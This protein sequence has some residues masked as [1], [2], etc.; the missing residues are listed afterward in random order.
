[1]LF[2][3]SMNWK[4]FII[5]PLLPV[6]GLQDHIETVHDLSIAPDGHVQAGL[7]RKESERALV[8]PGRG[9]HHSNA[10]A[11]LAQMM[12]IEAGLKCNSIV[13]APADPCPF[14]CP[15]LAEDAEFICHFRCLTAEQCGTL[16]PLA[17]IADRTDMICRQCKVMGC[18]DCIPGTKDTCRTCEPGYRL[19]E[20][21]GLCYS[22]VS[23]VLLII[24]ILC[25]LFMLTIAVVFIELFTRKKTNWKGYQEAVAYRWRTRLHM[26]LGT[27]PEDG[28]DDTDNVDA[29]TQELLL[30]PLSTNLLRQPVAGAGFCLH[31]N[32]CIAMLIWS[33][34]IIYAYAF[35][36][37]MVSIDML[38]LGL[39]PAKTSQQLC[40][41]VHWGHDAQM[42]LIW[43]KTSFI[44]F[45]YLFTF[46]GSLAFGVYQLKEFVRLDDECTMGDFAAYI[47]GLPRLSGSDRA[48]DD[49]AKFIQDTTGQEVRGVSIA[50]DYIDHADQVEAAID[51]DWKK[52]SLEIRPEEPEDPENPDPKQPKLGAFR[53]LFRRWDCL[54]GF[55]MPKDPPV[56]IDVDS[57]DFDPDAQPEEPLLQGE[58]EEKPEGPTDEEITTILNE[59]ESS[60]C[61]FIVF[62]TEEVRNAAVENIA[63]KKRAGQAILYKDRKICVTKKICEPQS[64]RFRGLAH[65]HSSTFR[66]KAMAKGC[67]ITLASLAGWCILLYLPYAYYMCSFS[68]AHGEEPDAFAAMLFTGLIVGGNQGMY[69]LADVISQNA[70]FGFEDDR[71]VA[72]NY[73]Y[74]TACVLNTVLDVGV[75]LFL[76]YRQMI[77]IGAHTADDRLLSSLDSFQDIFESYPIQKIFGELLF[78]YSF[79]AC[80]M[81]PFILEGVCTIIIPF[82]VMKNVVLSHDDVRGRD[83][84]KSMEYFL[85][86]NLGRYGDIIL[87]MILC[88]LVFLCPGGFTLPMFMA[89]FF[90]HAGIYIYDHSRTLRCTP[91]FWYASTDVDYFAQMQ[92]MIPTSV[93][94][95]CVYFRLMQM[96]PRDWCT[97]YVATILG[98]LALIGHCVLHWSCVKF[99]VPRYKPPAHQPSDMTYAQ[100]ATANAHTWFSVNPV[101]CLRSKF[102]FKDDPPAIHCV[103]GKEQLQRANEKIGAYFENQK[104]GEAY[105]GNQ[106]IAAEQ[107]EAATDDQEAIKPRMDM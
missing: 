64:V 88:S 71:E 87:N 67:M 42:R 92:L 2:L 23:W 25:G 91:A 43:A 20:K 72:Y 86:M 17:K 4:L 29:H 26:P 96:Y 38:V 99:L 10:S 55:T 73:V 57:P 76:A 9:H 32:F 70:E 100:V 47:T 79:P 58:E 95:V 15:F 50:W 24:K 37:C 62:D 90:C 18:E 66:V 27:A 39:S 36:A 101:H 104:Y 68:Y 60:D 75:V 21:D 83:A 53:K 63:A 98:I 94:A 49:L 74:V 34:V 59:M 7:M 52:R 8:R 35:S 16:D 6:Y 40:S 41:V 22:P 46:L 12:P 19:S 54:L 97:G 106:T 69:F 107:E 13:F 61:A 30:Y 56:S 82:Y 65:G 44:I 103:Y 84:E 48:E 77:G 14:E 102:I 93:L 51:A 5:I 33:A 11:A 89:F 3:D 78:E 80:F 85:P 31:M 28:V 105:S 1:M 81:I 45:A